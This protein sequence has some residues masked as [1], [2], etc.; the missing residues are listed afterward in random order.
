MTQDL[1]KGIL[2]NYLNLGSQTTTTD[3]PATYLNYI[4]F[5]KNYKVYDAGYKKMA[6]GITGPGN[7]VTKTFSGADE[8]TVT[9]PGYVFVFVTNESVSTSRIF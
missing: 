1:N 7:F 8:I 4:L 3:V 6:D 5:D 9:K 2:Y